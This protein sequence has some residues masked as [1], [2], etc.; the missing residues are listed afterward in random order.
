[1]DPM[2]DTQAIFRL[3]LDALARPGRVHQLPVAARDAPG[4]P[5]AAALLLT[6][7]DH[8]TSLWVAPGAGAAETEEF[9]RQRTAARQA[10]VEAADFVLAD[11]GDGKASP[12]AGGAGAGD[13][14]SRSPTGAAGVG[15]GESDRLDGLPGVLCRGTLAYPDGAATLVVAVPLIDQESINQD[16]IEQER[17]AGGLS[18]I[19]SGPGVPPPIDGSAEGGRTLWVRGL[20]APFFASREEAVRDYPTGVDLFLV[21]SAGRIAGLPRSTAVQIGGFTGASSE[22]HGVHE[23]HTGQREEHASGI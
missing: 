17:G 15:D 22:G 16:L 1:M 6:L 2:R 7:L 18:L 9:L 4:N 21:D 13:G 20:S 11:A 5:W 3:A 12:L 23:G 14:E 19:L 10:P 8:E